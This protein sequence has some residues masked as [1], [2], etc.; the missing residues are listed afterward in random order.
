MAGSAEAFNQKDRAEV[1]RER[2]ASPQPSLGTAATNRSVD[3][4]KIG[5][6]PTDLTVDLA[7]L[8]S[9]PGNTSGLIT[10][11]GTGVESEGIGNLT[12][13]RR[14]LFGSVLQAVHAVHAVQAVQTL[15]A[16]PSSNMGRMEGSGSR[17][18]L[19]VQQDQL[20]GFRRGWQRG[21]CAHEVRG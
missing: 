18:S 10:A 11:N 9:D 14:S 21:D 16:A 15:Q 3:A 5:S 6:D 8:A 20:D 2:A 19:L 7:D 12:G 17:R 13:G 1:L 4:P